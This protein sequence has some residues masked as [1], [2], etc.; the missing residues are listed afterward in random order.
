MTSFTI[1]YFH[2]RVLKR[3]I[4]A[5]LLGQINIIELRAGWTGHSPI[6]VGL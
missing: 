4:L 3:F 5:F 2:H 1:I 6:Q